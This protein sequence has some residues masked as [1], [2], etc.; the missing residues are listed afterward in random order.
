MDKNKIGFLFDL[1][2]VLIDSEREYSRIWA[3][4][5]QEFPTGVQSLEEKIKG[6]TLDKILDDHYP[7]ER[8]RSE[9]I[10][11]LYELESKMRYTYLLG[12]ESFLR[13]LKQE[14]LAT[15]MVTSSNDVKMKHLDE[16]LP[17]LRSFFDVIIT[18][19]LITHSKPDPEGYLLAASLLHKDIK[20][21]V[22]FEDSL[23][24][25]KAGRASGAYVVGISG[26]L[27]A[28]ILAPFADSVVENLSEIK[29]HTL[30]RNISLKSKRSNYYANE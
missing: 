2:G 12:S 7:D 17:E 4:V 10:A 8:V 24:G 3:Q 27:P 13:E 1:D 9:V 18:A 21:C 23:Q 20:N 6:C 22:V 15:A 28:E 16:E 19:D 14:E 29:L 25:V 26:T 5:N 11:R 30:I